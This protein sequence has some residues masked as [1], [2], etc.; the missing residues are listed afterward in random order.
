[1]ALI[2]HPPICQ[3]RLSWPSQPRTQTTGAHNSAML[4]PHPS[5]VRFSHPTP[6][7][8]YVFRLPCP[9]ASA[10]N[11]L[12]WMLLPTDLCE[13]EVRT[14]SSAFFATHPHRLQ[15]PSHHALRCYLALSEHLKSIH[16]GK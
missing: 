4:P 3:S 7:C 5:L 11:G 1:M 15:S 10:H 6:P 8:P 14:P 16:A 2:S 12:V 13:P 9:P